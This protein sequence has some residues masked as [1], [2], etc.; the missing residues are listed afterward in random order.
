[1]SDESSPSE[2]PEQSPPPPADSPALV[3]QPGAAAPPPSGHYHPNDDERTMGML[4]HLLAIL[5]GW[6]GVLVLWLVKRESSRFVDHNGKEAINFQITVILMA[7]GIVVI[8]AL[9]AI[10]TEGMAL[11]AVV[12]L[13]FIFIIL[14]LVFEIM[15]CI[16][17]NRGEWVHYPMTIRL[18]K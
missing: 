4:I 17:A 2:R 8:G 7:V 9:A 6:I 3:P 1:M 10:V 13:Y 16:R 12:P 15:A 18:I 5:T 11:I 14:I